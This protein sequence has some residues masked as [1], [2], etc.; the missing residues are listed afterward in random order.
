MTDNPAVPCPL[1][2]CLG[3]AGRSRLEWKLT[4]NY[5][6]FNC[7]DLIRQLGAAVGGAT[8]LVCSFRRGSSFTE[9]EGA[10]ATVTSLLDQL[11]SKSLLVPQT[12]FARDMV[13]GRT[14]TLS[15]GASIGL[16]VGCVVGGILLVVLIVLLIVC[17]QRRNH[18]NQSES[19][20][21]EMPV[22]SS[23]DSKSYI[24]AYVPPPAAPPRVM[25]L[26]CVYAV[27]EEGEGIL[28]LQPG[29][30]ATCDPQDWETTSEWVWV[31]S[32]GRSGYIPREFCRVV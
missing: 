8:L 20:Y 1:S 19:A 23:S 7:S 4:T 32:G 27:N 13:S 26:V 2:C 11:E 17:C 21:M 24:P 3:G 9:L 16:I 25:R 10:S 15:S 28:K 29:T 6:V 18:K 14:V 30:S 22:V 5:A 31:S 12:E